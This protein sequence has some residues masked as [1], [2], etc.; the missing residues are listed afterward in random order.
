MGAGRFSKIPLKYRMK[1][2]GK[3]KQTLEKIF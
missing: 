1:G 2:K 3:A